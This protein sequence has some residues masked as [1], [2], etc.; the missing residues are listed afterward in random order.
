[1]LL[2]R[3]LAAGRCLDFVKQT[4]GE[5]ARR[6]NLRILRALSGEKHLRIWKALNSEKKCEN[7][8]KSADPVL[9]LRALRSWMSFSL[10]HRAP[11]VLAAL[12]PKVPSKVCESLSEGPSE[13][14]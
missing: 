1:M 3:Q 5:R 14:L 12:P 2:L 4:Q 8:S 6:T 11:R 13:S 7:D 9:L 10:L